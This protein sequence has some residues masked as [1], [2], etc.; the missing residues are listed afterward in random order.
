[1]YLLWRHSYGGV[2][3]PRVQSERADSEE[4]RMAIEEYTR[5]S[6]DYL[7]T[8]V[9]SVQIRFTVA[10]A[11]VLPDVLRKVFPTPDPP[12]LGKAMVTHIVP[13][14]IDIPRVPTTAFPPDQISAMVK[15]S[16][17]DSAEPVATQYEAEDT[18][19]DDIL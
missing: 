16:E 7:L 1:M 15:E 17:T 11:M 6:R 8:Q 12:A 3:E 2:W 9:M 13:E 14:P 10:P 18:E 4:I 19:D 5:E